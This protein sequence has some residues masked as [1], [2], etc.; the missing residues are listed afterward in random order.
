MK[1]YTLGCGCWLAPHEKLREYWYDE[2]I[3]NAILPNSEKYFPP[4]LLFNGLL[5]K[6]FYESEIPAF[7]R[8]KDNTSLYLKI[9]DI[10]IVFHMDKP[11]VRFNYLNLFVKNNQYENFLK[12]SKD[13]F[14]IIDFQRVYGSTTTNERLLEFESFLLENNYNLDNFVYLD[15]IFKDRLTYKD[16]H[17]F[18]MGN[19]Y[20]NHEEDRYKNTKIKHFI[21]EYNTESG[22]NNYFN[23]WSTT[24]AFYN[25]GGL[26]Y[27]LN[28]VKK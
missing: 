13:M 15:V 11:K 2:S 12:I 22:Y 26:E 14:Y 7:E 23:I 20:K 9:P 18:R 10:G 3:F 19:L 1:I 28:R 16:I 4:K 17:W 6:K 27:I 25:N 21:Y 8:S 24:T 5:F